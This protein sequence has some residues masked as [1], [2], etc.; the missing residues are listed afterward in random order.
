MGIVSGAD[1]GFSGADFCPADYKGLSVER[2]LPTAFQ[3]PL[4]WH[5]GPLHSDTRT[6]TFS[7][8]AVWF[9]ENW[10]KT[11]KRIPAARNQAYGVGDDFKFTAVSEIS[12]TWAVRLVRPVPHWYVMQHLFCFVFCTHRPSFSPPPPVDSQGCRPARGLTPAIRVEA[13]AM[14]ASGLKPIQVCGELHRVWPW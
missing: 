9:C 8:I 13:V 6:P 11:K 14:L 5:F 2:R 7:K 12:L 4:F 1:S 10:H 3:R